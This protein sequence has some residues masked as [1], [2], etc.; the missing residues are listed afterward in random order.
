MANFVPI[1]KEQLQNTKIASKRHLGHI[2]KQHIIS[3][4]ADEYAQ[5]S[6]SFPIV[7]VKT[8]DS[9]RHQSVAMLGLETSENL[10][11]KNDEWI[12]LMLP[13]NAGLAPF[14][15]GLDP[16]QENTLV[17]YINLDSEFVGEDKE[18]PLFDEEGKETELLNNVQN[19][20]G[21]LYE[22]EKRTENLIKEL[23]E[24]DL[25]QEL[26]LNMAFASGE[27]KKLTGIFTIDEAKL[28]ALS[29]EKVLDFHKRGI[30]V[31]IYSMLS[32]LAQINRLVQLR[33]ETEDRKIST[34]QIVPVKKEEAAA[35]AETTAS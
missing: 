3:V 7:L 31:P 21:R 22:N 33:N 10:Y 24:N 13:K 8:P 17:P 14:S 16:D 26:E 19:S 1:R 2:A 34:I 27:K 9:P 12:G 25:L 30:F 6:S 32:S 23:V 11:Y 29:D 18:L 15:L 5:A 4:T 28:K 20:L 35:E